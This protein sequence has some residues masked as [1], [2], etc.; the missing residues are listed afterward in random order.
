MVAQISAVNMDAQSG[1][2]MEITGSDGKTVA[3]A[4]KL[5]SRDLSGIR[6]VITVSD[7][8][9]SGQRN[10]RRPVPVPVTG[11]RYNSFL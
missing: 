5:S 8:S 7:F 1:S 2:L 4:T 10:R 9:C 6:N 11:V 3:Q